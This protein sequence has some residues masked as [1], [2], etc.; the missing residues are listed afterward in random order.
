M[1]RV[2]PEVLRRL[3]PRAREA[4]MNTHNLL[5]AATS[6]AEADPRVSAVA[7]IGSHARGEAGPDSAVKQVAARY[8]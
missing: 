7:L 3:S 8:Q 6:W 1:F 5:K 4:M 2:D